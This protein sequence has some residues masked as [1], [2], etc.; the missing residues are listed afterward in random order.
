VPSELRLR[1][2]GSVS[3]TCCLQAAITSG[4]VCT[5]VALAAP[6]TALVVL[7]LLRAVLAAVVAVVVSETASSCS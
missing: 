2:T 5:S 4:V 3:Q 6:H 7:L 1:R